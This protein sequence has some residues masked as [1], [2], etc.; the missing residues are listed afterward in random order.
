MIE[1]VKCPKCQGPMASRKSKHG[2]FWGCRAFPRCNGTR[3]ANAETAE[4]RG[5][6]PAQAGRRYE[7]HQRDPGNE[8]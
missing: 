3:D 6:P 8:W 7:G 2:P 4:D 1:D 5:H